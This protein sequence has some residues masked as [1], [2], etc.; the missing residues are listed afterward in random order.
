[1]CVI[2]GCDKPAVGYGLCQKHY[3]RYIRALVGILIWVSGK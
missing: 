2:S 3:M 1:M